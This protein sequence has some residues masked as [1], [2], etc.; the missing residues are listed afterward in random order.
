MDWLAILLLAYLMRG[1]SRLLTDFRAEPQDQPSYVN[2]SIS[3]TAVAALLWWWRKR[4][5][6]IVVGLIWVFAIFGMLYW[7]LGFAITSPVIRLAILSIPVIHTYV[8]A[9]L[10]RPN[11]QA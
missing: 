5:L 7:L 11:R 6:Q 10:S 9:L 3:M 2:G 1:G 4:P 8:A